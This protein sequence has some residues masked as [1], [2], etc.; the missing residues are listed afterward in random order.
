MKIPARPHTLEG[1]TYEVPILS[2]TSTPGTD[3]KIATGNIKIV[4]N[5][6]E[7]GIF[8]VFCYAQ[9]DGEN[10]SDWTEALGRSISIGLR[11]GIPV[12]TYIEQLKGIRNSPIWQGR[13]L[14]Q[15]GPDGIA[16][17]LQEEQ[18]YLASLRKTPVLPA[19][20]QSLEREP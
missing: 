3:G 8:E 4:I 20:V 19:Q 7:M 2:C 5:H 13:E 18:A 10:I 11:G 1:G 6:N 9:I 15:S 14:I 17:A 16:K 12:E